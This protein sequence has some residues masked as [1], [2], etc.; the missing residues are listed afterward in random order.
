MESDLDKLQDKVNKL[1]VRFDHLRDE[2]IGK[3]NKCSHYLENAEE[4]CREAKQKHSILNHKLA[5]VSSEEKE[6]KEIQK[7]LA[8]TALSGKVI[9]DVG[10]EKYTTSVETLTREKQTF[11]TALFSQQW[12]LERDPD[13]KTIFIDRDGKLFHYIL[14]YLRNN[15]ISMDV[16]ENPSLRQSLLLEAE[17]FHLHKLIDLLSEPERRQEEEERR[18]GDLYFPDSTLLE[19]KQKFKLNEFYGKLDQRWILL[20]KAS[21]DGFDEGSFHA[22][23]DNQGPTMTII[24]SNNNYLFGGYT[25][26]PWTSDNGSYKNDST[27]FLFTLT[28]PHQIPPT[29]YLIRS[30]N[31]QYAVYHHPSYG[32]TFGSGHDICLANNRDANMTCY[33]SFSGTFY[34]TTG[35]GNLTF[36]GAYN[37]TPSDVEVYK[38]A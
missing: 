33:S 16:M 14:N 10:G 6:W 36:T 21:R 27:A 4:L 11:F 38:L 19:P 35:Q 7:K 3:L 29:K 30:G 31:T 1:R 5:H 20:Y 12:Q 34:D 23:C 28:N 2:M 8:S 37:F 32:S 22:L 13:D 18:L 25:A 9:L 17:Y 15:R 26:I 24:L